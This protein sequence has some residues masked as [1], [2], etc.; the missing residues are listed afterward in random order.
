MRFLPRDDKFYDF[1]EKCAQQAVQ[2][3]VQLEQLLRNF[4]DV[5]VKAKQIKD[6]EHEGD[7][8]THDT[9]ENL[10]RTFITPFDR[11]DIHDLITS[12]DDVLD[13][14]EACAERLFLFKIEKTTEESIL[15]CGVLVK[16]VKQL[17]QAVSQLR[18]LKDADSI[19]RHCAEINRLE[20]EGDYL[21]RAAVAKLFEPNSDPLEVIK[22]K[23]IYET[24]E[25]VTDRCEDVANVIEGIV[26]E[27]S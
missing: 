1:F 2:G 19:L 15:I 4:N 16:S 26:I 23:E 8:I 17:E 7:L 3:A 12:L 25:I 6:I 20:N 10:N 5:Q 11:E 9:I 13:Y 18:R 22:W 14:I 27:N 21:N 24:M